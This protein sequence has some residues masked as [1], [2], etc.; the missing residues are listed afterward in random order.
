MENDLRPIVLKKELEVVVSVQAQKVLESSKYT[1]EEFIKYALEDQKV[2]LG[3][4]DVTLFLE[5]M[6]NREKGTH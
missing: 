4:N 3:G 5:R 6:Y 1:V 2:A